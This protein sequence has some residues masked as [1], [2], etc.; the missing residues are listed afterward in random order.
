MVTAKLVLWEISGVFLDHG[1]LLNLLG[2]AC[3]ISSSWAVIF[4]CS[5]H[6]LP[7]ESLSSTRTCVGWLAM[8]DFRPGPL[9]WHV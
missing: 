6:G 9:T 2:V 7:L 4:C 5:E 1:N 8:A 3:G